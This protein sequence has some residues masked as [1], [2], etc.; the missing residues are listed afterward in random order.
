MDGNFVIHKGAIIINNQLHFTSTCG[1]TR[2]NCQF[3]YI[4]LTWFRDDQCIDRRGESGDQ[5]PVIVKYNWR[6]YI[7]CAIE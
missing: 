7:N 4:L 1:R 3:K 5:P 6:D 2:I